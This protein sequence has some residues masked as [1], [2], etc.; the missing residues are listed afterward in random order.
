MARILEIDYWKVIP[1]RRGDIDEPAWTFSKFAF[2]NL[3]AVFKFGSVR[4][5]RYIDHEAFFFL[6]ESN[7][8]YEKWMVNCK[9]SKEFQD[10]LT[11]VE[12]GGQE[13]KRVNCDI[14]HFVN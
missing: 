10:W 12:D 9:L 13:Y 7:S 6:W 4:V 8:E 5:G 3:D 1:G 11:I 14:I 2:K